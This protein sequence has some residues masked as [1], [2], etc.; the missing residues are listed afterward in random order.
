MLLPYEFALL[1]N[2]GTLSCPLDLPDYVGD[3]ISLPIQIQVSPLMTHD[4]STTVPRK[5]GHGARPS[6]KS[7]R[8]SA[9]RNVGPL[10][11]THHDITPTNLR[12]DRHD[13]AGMGVWKKGSYIGL[14]SIIIEK[15][16]AARRYS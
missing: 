8:Q 15:R 6:R 13:G 7:K 2:L 16:I 5:T 11:A 1:V 12:W 4:R 10:R 3:R 9:P 14:L